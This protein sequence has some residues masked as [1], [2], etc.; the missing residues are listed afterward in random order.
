[1]ELRHTTEELTGIKVGFIYKLLDYLG[2]RGD[3]NNFVNDFIKI[4]QL[5]EYLSGRAKKKY[6]HAQFF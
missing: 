1:M 2:N 3:Y 6:D 5:I 4:Q